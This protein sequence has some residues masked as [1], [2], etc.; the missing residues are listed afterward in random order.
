MWSAINSL[1]S[2]IVF[3]KEMALQGITT[4]KVKHMQRVGNSL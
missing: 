3:T 2:T 1:D 4:R